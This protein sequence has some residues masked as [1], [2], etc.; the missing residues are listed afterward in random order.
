MTHQ[1]KLIGNLAEKAALIFLK[2][3]GLKLYQANFYSRFGEI[4]LIMLD[5]DSYVFVE[6]KKRSSGIN[7]AFESI[8]LAKQRKLIKAA[9]FFLLKLG[10]DVNCR[11]DAVAL[12]ADEQIEWIKNII[13]L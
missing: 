3:Q 11:F 12:N 6:V 10:K 2:E 5:G 8:N 9:Q 13:V 7:L 1:N 4:D